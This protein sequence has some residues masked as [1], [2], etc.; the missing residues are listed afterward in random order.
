[1]LPDMSPNN[2]RPKRLMVK[3]SL[4]GRNPTSYDMAKGWVCSWTSYKD[5]KISLYFRQQAIGNLCM[6]AAA[7]ISHRL[8]RRHKGGRCGRRCWRMCG[9]L[10]TKPV[11]IL[12]TLPYIDQPLDVETYGF[13][14]SPSVTS[15]SNEGEVP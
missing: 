6:A 2:V 3:T 12:S 7:A 13:D 5:I 8:T 10:T 11:D 9:E 1:M 15:C 14:T 4:I